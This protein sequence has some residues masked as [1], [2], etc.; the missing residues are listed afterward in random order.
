MP[1]LSRKKQANQL[2][3]IAMFFATMLVI[4]FMTSFIFNVIPFPIK[5]TLVHVP[6]IIASI[7]YG[8]RI[9]GILG[10]LMGIISVIANTF[11][12]LP[13]SYLF[14]PFVPN[15]SFLSLIIAIVPRVLIG[16]TPYFVYKWLH[17]KT[18]LIIAGAIG[19]MTNTFFVLGGI[20]ILFANVYSGDIQA[21]LA[22]VFGGNAIAEMLISA[23]LTLAIV[24]SLQ[25]LAKKA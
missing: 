2:A 5:P 21:M 14:S 4:H 22:V 20:F 10:F 11:V 16:I 18:G 7:I 1:S 13:T 15:G 6:V 23:M 8:P 3:V 19:S 25:K 24:P 17:H 12:L 9:G